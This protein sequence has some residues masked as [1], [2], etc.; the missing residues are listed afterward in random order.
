MME[1]YD[2]ALEAFEKARR[3]V[4]DV[5]S[6]LAAIGQTLA[7]T[8]R[9]KEA[10][11]RLNDLRTLG[12]AQWVPS[13]CFAVVYLGLGDHENSLTWLESATENR[14]IAV[15]ALNVHPMYDPLRAEP[16][17]RALLHRIKFLP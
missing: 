4:G 13:M 5:P 15:T 12:N 11:I 7:S 1:R 14:E 17:F 2:D 3:L 16:R 8:G 6:L 9:T 10:R